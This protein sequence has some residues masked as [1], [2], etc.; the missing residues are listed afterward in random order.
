MCAV[1]IYT[2]CLYPAPHLAPHALQ[3]QAHTRPA[4]P[5]HTHR[6]LQAAHQALRAQAHTQAPRHRHHHHVRRRLHQAPRHRHHHH[7]AA[8]RE[9]T[10]VYVYVC[11]HVYVVVYASTLSV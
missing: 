10:C 2:L 1:L 8:P 11:L 3:V 4:A 6:H 7:Q 9:F 5:A